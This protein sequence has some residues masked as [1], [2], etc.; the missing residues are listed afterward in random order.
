MSDGEVKLEESD[1]DR[2]KVLLGNNKYT[3]T[4]GE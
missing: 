2:G 1:E 4:R 3:G